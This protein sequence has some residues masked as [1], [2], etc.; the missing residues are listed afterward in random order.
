MIVTQTETF[1]KPSFFCHSGLEP[2]SSIF[3]TGSRLSPGRRLD[4]R[5]RTLKGTSGNDGRHFFLFSGLSART[6]A[7][8][9]HISESRISLSSASSLTL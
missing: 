8:A 9:C 6:A 2:E 4:S 7:P 3:I 5:L 1:E